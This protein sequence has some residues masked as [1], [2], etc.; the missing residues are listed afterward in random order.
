MCGCEWSTLNVFVGR[1]CR[2]DTTNRFAVYDADGV[3]CAGY[4]R[5]DHVNAQATSQC[6]HAAHTS[7]VQQCTCSR[8]PW[9]QPLRFHVAWLRMRHQFEDKT[10]HMTLAYNPSRIPE[11]ELTNAQQW[12]DAL[13]LA[14]VAAKEL[15]DNFNEIRNN[16]W[17]YVPTAPAPSIS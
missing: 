17:H 3:T 9:L 14:D 8:R 11:E 12:L 16:R 1:A 5:I 10:S 2:R 6:C 15:I 7:V 13:C 4:I